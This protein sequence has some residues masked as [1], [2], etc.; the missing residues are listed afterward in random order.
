MTLNNCNEGYDD[1]ND[2]KI[3]NNNNDNDN[4][5]CIPLLLC[6]LPLFF[7][8]ITAL[9]IYYQPIIPFNCTKSFMCSSNAFSAFEIKRKIKLFSTI[10]L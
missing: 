4:D 10:V 5:Y 8:L 6:V 9:N 7:S 1:D 3:N 2:D